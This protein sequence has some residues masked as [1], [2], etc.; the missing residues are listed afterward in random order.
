MRVLLDDY[1]Q[2][3]EVATKLV[4]TAPLV[5]STG[6]DHLGDV[7]ALREFLSVHGLVTTRPAARDLAAVH[8]LRDRLR[9]VVEQADLAG[10]SA[11]TGSARTVTIVPDR[12][13]AVDVPDDAA[14][15]HLLAVVA[16]LGVLGARLH[17]G[18]E[19]FRT[20][21]AGCPGLFI[22]TSRAG[23]RRYCMPELCGNRINTAR[24]RARRR[25]FPDDSREPH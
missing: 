25:S 21:A 13:W 8:D 11:L 1:V 19:R 4:N 2:H 20:C 24:H 18:P 9:P 15:A 10:A 22:D 5:W 12:G 16:G 17:L 6:V 3:A 14:A 23:R 7:P